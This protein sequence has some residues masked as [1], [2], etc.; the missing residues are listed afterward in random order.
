MDY[1]AI[2]AD[3]YVLIIALLA[4]GLLTGLLAGML[5]IGGG[6]VLVPILYEVFTVIGIDSDIRTHMAVGTSL[7]VIIPTSISSFRAHHSRGA[8]DMDILRN[9]GPGVFIGVLL[10]IYLASIVDGSWLRLV[11]VGC[12]LFIAFKLLVAR[13]RLQFGKDLPGQPVAGMMGG[14]FGMA[15]TLMGVGGGALIS[16]TMTLFGRAIHQAVATSSG[17]GPIIAIPATIGYIWAGWGLEA[18]PVG[19]AGYVSLMG[20]AIIIPMSV[21]A[22]PYGVRISHGL[23]K[24]KLET[25]FGIFLLIVSIRF[26]ISIL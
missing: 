9:W 13:D 4:G 22:A 3:N 1:A 21:L 5:G 16:S 6:G 2:L 19:S 8:V 12:S 25:A 7:A 18:L 15:S 26:I 14:V 11:Y 17:F 24:R 23:S 10:G 20:A